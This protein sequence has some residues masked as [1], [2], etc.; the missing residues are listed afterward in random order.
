MR[1]LILI[2]AAL[3]ISSCTRPVQ[4]PGGALAQ[5]L[6]GRVAGQPQSCVSASTGQNLRVVDSRTVATGFGRTIHV[7]HLPGECP[8]LAP[9][10]TIIADVHGGQY[11]R[12]DH[13]RALEPGTII[14][15]P[16]CNLGD[17]V[18]YRKP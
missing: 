10:N 11:C 5:E 12:G 13:I 18:P 8:G 3:V 1:P 17:W 15:G 6:A 7:N 9:L 16:W 4:P 2:V 14:P